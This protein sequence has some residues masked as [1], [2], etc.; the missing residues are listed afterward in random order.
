[1]NN[2]SFIYFDIKENKEIIKYRKLD[3]K[4]VEATDITPSYE[5]VFINTENDIDDY[6]L[7]I[8]PIGTLL[9]DFLNISLD[10]CYNLKTFAFKYGIDN[11]LY[12]DKKNI[13]HTYVTYPV[14]EFNQLF[15]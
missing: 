11:L 2:K 6:E 1:M 7:I 4:F 12:M 5:S 8:Q 15:I 3:E 13:L 14:K 10:N 9:L